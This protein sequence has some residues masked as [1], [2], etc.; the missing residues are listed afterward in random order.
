MDLTILAVIAELIEE[1]TPVA[2]GSVRRFGTVA[3]QAR[4]GTY[5]NQ[6]ALH[7][8]AQLIMSRTTILHTPTAPLERSAQ[9]RLN[10][11]LAGIR[12]EAVRLRR[13]LP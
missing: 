2:F 4:I 13:R 5:N 9:P 8:V 7:S 6:P 12:P 11:S 3:M 1:Q 10:T